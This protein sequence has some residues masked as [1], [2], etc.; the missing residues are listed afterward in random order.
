MFYYVAQF[1]LE[2]LTPIG[3]PILLLSHQFEEEYNK[4]DI[5]MSFADSSASYL[6][7][8][9][10]L[11]LGKANFETSERFVVF[12]EDLKKI[13]THNFEG[14]TEKYVVELYQS[15]VDKE[16]NL[17]YLSGITE[18]EVKAKA[19]RNDINYTATKKY[20]FGKIDIEKKE[21]EE[22]EIELED[23]SSIISAEFYFDSNQVAHIAG[24]Y[25]SNG[26]GC[27]CPAS[28]KSSGFFSVTLNMNEFYIENDSYMKYDEG[29]FS[30]ASQGQTKRFTRVGG[31]FSTPAREI[32]Q[33]RKGV[34]CLFESRI[35]GA[36]GEYYEEIIVLYVDEKGE[37]EWYK[38]IEKNQST[39]QMDVNEYSP[40]QQMDANEY[41]FFAFGSD[42]NLVILF[43]APAKSVTAYRSQKVEDKKEYL[44]VASLNTEQEFRIEALYS[45]NEYKYIP[46]VKSAICLDDNT[47]FIPHRKGKHDKYAVLKLAK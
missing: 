23:E 36:F 11:P 13:H 40:S 41:S 5:E 18:Y 8:C 20:Y 15:T 46:F 30:V 17:F 22:L 27:N 32:I 12:D 42:D 28:K 29:F 16:G 25:E 35:W 7:L 1:S 26:L 43:M 3:E 33:A 38:T 24:L 37:V 44:F 9:E 31:L 47:F 2:D 21:T 34:F 10:T 39:Q 14:A 6:V 45:K 19:K 4:G